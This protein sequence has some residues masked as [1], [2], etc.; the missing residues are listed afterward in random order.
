MS[1]KLLK[2]QRRSQQKQLRIN[3]EETGFALV[4]P[5]SDPV[6]FL[7]FLVFLYDK[8]YYVAHLIPFIVF[9]IRIVK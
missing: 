9:I 3:H 8:D 4:F 6:L 5:V 7:H 2:K 1:K